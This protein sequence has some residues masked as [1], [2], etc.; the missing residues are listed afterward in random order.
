[1][2]SPPI[3]LSCVSASFPAC[4]LLDC[5]SILFSILPNSFIGRFPL[6][7]IVSSLR[8]T[9]L[10]PLSHLPR[11]ILLPTCFAA[12]PPCVINWWN[13][14]Q[15][16]AVYISNMRLTRVKRMV[17]AAIRCRRKRFSL[18]IPATSILS[19]G[20]TPRPRVRHGR[21]PATPAPKDIDHRQHDG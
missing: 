12:N 9:R 6:L 21:I 14:F 20:A 5:A 7:L 2:I 1:M 18:D 13:G 3:N 16:A 11:H 8:W 4:I 19:E 15:S 17:N 10:S